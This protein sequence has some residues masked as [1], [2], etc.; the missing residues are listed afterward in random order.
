MGGWRMRNEAGNV[1]GY[2]ML[3]LHLINWRI[4]QWRAIAEPVEKMRH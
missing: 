3:G 2:V 1:I 4:C